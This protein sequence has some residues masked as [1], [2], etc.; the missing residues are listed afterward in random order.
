MRTALP[1]FETMFAPIKLVIAGT[2]CELLQATDSRFV[3]LR[4]PIE[5]VEDFYRS[6]DCAAVP[7][8]ASTGLKIKTG[9]ALSLGVPIVSLTHAFEGYEPADTLHQLPD[10][11]AMANALVDLSFAARDRLDVLAEASRTSYAVTAAAIERSF[12]ETARRIRAAA[13]SIV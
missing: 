9:E 11:E 3:E 5:N 6:I 12:R 13:P 10:F 1:V 8:R 2:I 4:G 7:M